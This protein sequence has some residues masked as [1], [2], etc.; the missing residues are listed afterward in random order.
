MTPDQA[1]L[2]KEFFGRELDQL[3]DLVGRARADNAREHA[4]VRADMAEIRGEISDV[5]RRV[6]GVEE[7]DRLDRKLGEQR[8]Q[9][10]RHVAYMLGIAAAVISSVSALIAVL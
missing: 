5:G 1:N 10:V 2:L 8:R 9:I 6:H 7:H 4:Q 3:R